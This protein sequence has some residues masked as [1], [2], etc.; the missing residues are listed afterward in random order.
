[1]HTNFFDTL[2]TVF[3]FLNTLCLALDHY[4]MDL[5]QENILT[6]LNLAFTWVF[7]GEMALKIIAMGPVKYLKDKI[8]HMDCLVV[9]ISITELIVISSSFSGAHQSFRS[10]R[11]FR[12]FR[13]IRIG[14]LLRTFKSMQIIMD[15]L[16]KSMNSFI[17]LALLLFLFLF[18][19]TLLGMQ[20]FGGNMS[21]DANFSGDP[22][23]PRTNYDS[24][25]SAFLTC[26]QLL[27]MEGWH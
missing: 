27:T 18:I 4:G 14:K 3:V 9:V 16:I 25:N 23:V 24:F 12:I 2:M 6:Q 17:Y 21:F 11:I 5:W 22:G 7:F 15:V 19:F 8:N 13:I 1:V 20:I 26:F 10:V